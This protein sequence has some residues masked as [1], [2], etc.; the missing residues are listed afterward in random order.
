MTKINQ[1][2]AWQ[3]LQQHYQQIKPL[4][5]S[6]L[7]AKHPQRADIFSLQAA[8]LLLDYSKNRITTETMTLLL[9]L[10]EI[11]NLKA[12]INDLF[13]GGKVNFTEQRPALHTE[14]RAQPLKESTGQ[15][16]EQMELFIDKIYSGVYQGSTGKMITDI[17]NIGIGGSD[18]GPRFVV[19][20]LRPY[21]QEK[22]KLHFVANIDA[23]EIDNTL[24]RLNP[25][26]TLFIVA[27]KSFTTL[28]TL[29]NATIAKT[30]LTQTLGSIAIA[31]QFIAIT[32][33]PEHAQQFGIKQNNIFT[34]A[35]SIGG[36][37]SLWSTMGLSI[38]LA[39]GMNNF[40]QL[41]KGAHLMDQHFQTTPLNRNMPVILALLSIWYI[42]FFHSQTQAIIPYDEY[43]KLLPAYLQQL[44]MESN[45]KSI[46]RQGKKINYPTA[47]IIWGGVGS[48]GQHAFHQLL[49]QGSGLI[50][51]DFIIIANNHHSFTE[52]QDLLVANCLAQSQALMQGL[53]EQQAYQQLARNL[54]EIEAK[55]LAPHCIVAG[56]KPSNTLLLPELNP[57]TLGSLIALYEHKVFTQGI[58]WQINSFDQYGVELGKKLANDLLDQNTVKTLDSSTQQLLRKYN[59]L[60]KSSQ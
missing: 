41:L 7:F 26:T 33:K 60:K 14:L 36:R 20:A 23:T 12:A 18:L 59:T 46:N 45:G 47:A 39:I 29:T 42:N 55:R 21:Q 40:K 8:D 50:P 54:N 28:E 35:D 17:V 38:A 58:I 34:F 57:T 19:D 4:Q 48:N 16:L 2:A 10:A 1:T 22:F 31:N 6:T 24:K 3:Q 37:Y 25:E 11:V 27:S 44:E 56:N 51:V 52:Q 13:T 43:L 15:A 53:N 5:L 32:A 30:W 49:H 9:D